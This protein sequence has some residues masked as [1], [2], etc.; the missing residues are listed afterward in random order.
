MSSVTD[1]ITTD[2]TFLSSA[3]LDSVSRPD[4]T[5]PV[6]SPRSSDLIPMQNDPLNEAALWAELWEVVD[7][8]RVLTPISVLVIALSNLTLLGHEARVVWRTKRLI[9]PKL[10]ALVLSLS[11]LLATVLGYFPLWILFEMSI[12]SSD[13]SL[14]HKTSKPVFNG[15]H[16]ISSTEGEFGNLTTVPNLQGTSTQN[17]PPSPRS[18]DTDG[19]VR[20]V[21]YAVFFFL[22][23]SCWIM[24]QYTVV[25]MAIERFV[26]LRTPYFYAVRVSCLACVGVVGI[27]TGLSCG[28]G[29]FHIKVHLDEVKNHLLVY[30]G[31]LDSKSLPHNV[32]TLVQGVLCTAVLLV[33][34]WA[35]TRELRRMERCVTVMR[36]KDQSDYMKQLSMV[37]G[38]G[39]EFARFM[40]AVNIVYLLSSCPKL[41]CVILRLGNLA[42]RFSVQY[43][44]WRMSH[45]SA[46]LNPFLYGFLRKSLRSRIR[47]FLN[48]HAPF[49]RPRRVADDSENPGPSV[50]YDN[51]D[52]QRHAS[53]SS[54]I[55][56]RDPEASLVYF[57]D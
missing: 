37:H 1:A 50:R 39:R 33:C 40:M 30:V 31:F 16:S 27:L 28:I 51:Q 36:M 34:N 11:D 49:M 20:S 47:N 44:C 22:L 43:F 45:I 42:P 4:H 46:F 25:V 48:Q 56:P 2:G 15:S 8:E 17:V 19:V 3:D 24:A 38:A 5:K 57:M 14:L 52:Y 35:V 32:L 12:K 41:V 7:V 10:L 6:S 13:R 54:I 29:A 55:M 21:A 53:P 23:T 26:A 9:P 18:L